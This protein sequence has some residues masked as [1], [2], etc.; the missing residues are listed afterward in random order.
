MH[1]QNFIKVKILFS[2]HLLDCLP[3]PASPWHT[4]WIINWPP[5]H[6]HIMASLDWIWEDWRHLHFNFTTTHQYTFLQS[7]SSHHFPR[8]SL[9]RSLHKS[10]LQS[11]YCCN[12]RLVTLWTLI[13]RASQCNRN[14]AINISIETNTKTWNIQH[15]QPIFQ[16]Q[17]IFFF[18][19]IE[20]KEKVHQL[21][22]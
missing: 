18:S 6:Y 21:G 10:S 2:W 11:S 12:R 22:S 4:C 3:P 17:S 7:H 1:I 8:P 5:T 14:L 19:S 15:R 20:I 16:F 13:L 9:L